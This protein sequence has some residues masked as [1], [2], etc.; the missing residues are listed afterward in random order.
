MSLG[1]KKGDKVEIK[2]GRSKGKSGKILKV[3]KSGSRVLV[4]GAQLAKKHMRR[5]SEAEPGGVKEVPASIN[6]SN[7]ALYCPQ[8]NKGT[9]FTV[10]VLQDKSKVRICTKC[11]KTI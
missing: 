6:V 5:R 11:K 8:C 10:K 3:I 9:R 1:I 7:V 2:S 4:E